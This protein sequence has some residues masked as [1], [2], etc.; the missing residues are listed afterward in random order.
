[1][2]LILQIGLGILLGQVLTFVLA[3]FEDWWVR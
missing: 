2:I 3:R 1:M